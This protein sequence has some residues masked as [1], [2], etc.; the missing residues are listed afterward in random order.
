MLVLN[1]ENSVENK[2]HQHKTSWQD[3]TS[4]SIP[5]FPYDV[6]LA[7]G[8]YYKILPIS[9]SSKLGIV[10]I[11]L[12]MYIILYN[13]SYMHTCVNRHILPGIFKSVQPRRGQVY[14][15]LI[16]PKFAHLSSAKSHTDC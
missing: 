13:I 8:N 9:S 7:L 14:F 2:D 3:L 4:V 10:Y 16:S 12:K 1:R 6:K 11:C 5:S 15:V